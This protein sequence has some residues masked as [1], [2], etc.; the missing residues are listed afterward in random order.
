MSIPKPAAP[1]APAVPAAA[2]AAPAADSTLAVKPGLS[3][4]KPAAPATPATADA[5]QVLKKPGLSIPKPAA[6]AAPA[7]VAPAAPAPEADPE[8]EAKRVQSEGL[9]P[10]EG[11]KTNI[12]LKKTEPGSEG[13]LPDGLK[14]TLELKPNG[15][16]EQ[17]ILKSSSDEPGVGLTIV[18]VAA[19]IL[20]LLGTYVLFANYAKLWM[21]EL[22][23]HNIP[24]P[25]S[26][27]LIK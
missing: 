8:A 20:L 21:P 15:S 1:A 25:P 12:G 6:P 7:P 13:N 3:I 11:A 2:P 16:G 4:P 5:T 26:G 19:C 22:D 14:P 10:R 24:Q 9:K 23:A 18:T 27:L 17:I